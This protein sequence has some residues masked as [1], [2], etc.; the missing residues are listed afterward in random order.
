MRPEEREYREL[1]ANLFSAYIMKIFSENFKARKVKH[2]FQC[3]LATVVVAA[4]LIVI[5]SV[6]ETVIVAALGASAFIAFAMP[7][8]AVSGPRLLIGG[9]LIGIAVG[10]GCHFFSEHYLLTHISFIQ[11]YSRPIFGSIS[12]GTAI[13]L[14]TIT[15]TEHPPAAGLALGFVLNGWSY[16]T[17]EVVLAGIVLISLI[18]FMLRRLLINLV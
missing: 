18:K 9:Y 8:R 17:I 1:N 6:A 4:V 2:L 14:M 16:M 15:D 5:S 11:T 3:T 10:C 7:H 13:F 12:V